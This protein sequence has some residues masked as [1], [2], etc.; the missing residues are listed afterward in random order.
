[1][2][3]NDLTNKTAIVTGAAQGLSCGMAEGLMEVFLSM[4]GIDINPGAEKTA[5]EMTDRGFQCS[6]VIADIADDKEREQAFFRSGEASRRN[7]GYYR[8]R[9]GSTEAA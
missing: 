9:S 2:D 4:C 3:L 5:Q 7:I 1:M 6:F 8:Q